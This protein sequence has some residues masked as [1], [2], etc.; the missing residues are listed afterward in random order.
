MSR[1]FLPFALLF[2]SCTAPTPPDRATPVEPSGTGAAP[3]E[4]SADPI[5]PSVPE[6]PA[7][8]PRLVRTTVGGIAIEA[9]AFDARSHRLVVVDQP[10]GPGSR[11][12]DARNAGLARGGLAAVNG[13]F[14]TPDGAPL[15]RVV[16]S[17]EIAGAV[18]RAGSLGS[19][20]FV[21]QGDR[22]ALVRRERFAGGD[23]VLQAGPFLVEG[24]RSVAGLS[25]KTSSARTFVATDDRGGWVIARTGACSLGGLADALAG[26]TLAGVKVR[27]ALNLDGGRSS[28]LWV[29]SSVAGGP[30]FNRPLW[31]KPVR[32][33]LV[34]ESRD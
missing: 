8:A 5:A 28:E 19:G 1:L 21:G 2:A 22:P 13:G 17:G 18:N 32:N 27:T 16:A 7:Q 4:A 23:Q 29:S 33:F 26:T 20:F 3:G 15:G 25:P 11:W 10:S 14:F 24:G 31:N 12:S 6:R 30:T 34:L 9:V